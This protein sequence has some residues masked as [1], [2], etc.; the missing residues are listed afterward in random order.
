M[1]GYIAL[2]SVIIAVIYIIYWFSNSDNRRRSEAAASKLASSGVFDTAA[3]AS[4]TAL[5]AIA[6]PNAADRFARGELIYHNAIGGREGLRNA[7]HGMVT[8]AARD[9]AE[10]ARGIIGEGLDAGNFHRDDAMLRVIADFGGAVMDDEWAIRAG[11]AQNF[12]VFRNAPAAR[13]VETA[14]VIAEKATAETNTRAEAISSALKAATAWQDDRQNVHDSAV[15]SDLNATLR[16]IRGGSAVGDSAR[17]LDEI[18]EY[19]AAAD[20]SPERRAAAARGLQTARTGSH[21]STFNDTE[22]R[23]L[24][25]VWARCDHPRNRAAKS[26][27][28]DAVIAAL[29]DGTEN[30]NQVCIN[31]RC[32]R[33]ISALTA[34]DFDPEVSDSPMTFEAYRNQIFQETREI[35][36]SVIDNAAES[37]DEDLRAVA[38]SYDGGDEASD[39]ANAK[40]IAVLK[41]E[42]DVLIDGYTDKI[43]ENELN[44]I[45]SE[46]YVYAAI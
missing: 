26:D 27:L 41:G 4:L 30:G 14:A 33:I 36:D 16:K 20:L 22:D 28:R 1:F 31:G 38:A 17:V 42:I 2:V 25:A 29:A 44:G 3:R 45:R 34:I 7:P 37:P 9:F 11:L 10:A 12:D 40:F 24:T 18:A 32:G 19:L 6:N 13:R 23:I 8:A 43:G 39:A 21:I 15:N 46:C 5:N 35:V